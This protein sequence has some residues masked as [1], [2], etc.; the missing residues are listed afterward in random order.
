[1]PKKIEWSL[2]IGLVGCRVTGEFEVTNDL[3]DSELEEMVRDE[4][5]NH[6]EWNYTVDGEPA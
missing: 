2:S 5:M 4:V 6:V 3:L 1:M